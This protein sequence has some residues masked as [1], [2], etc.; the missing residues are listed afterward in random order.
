MIVT[1][2]ISATV[3][4]DHEREGVVEGAAGSTLPFS[5]INIC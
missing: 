5:K 3:D 4:S 1:S 2:G